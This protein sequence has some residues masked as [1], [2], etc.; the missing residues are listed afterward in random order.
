[1]IESGEESVIVTNLI[2]RT[3][4]MGFDGDEHANNLRE[5]SSWMRSTSFAA[6]PAF[7]DSQNLAKVVTL[8]EAIWLWAEERKR[9]CWC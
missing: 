8:W 7:G 9:F 4:V 5:L 3:S 1:V 2:A 6:V